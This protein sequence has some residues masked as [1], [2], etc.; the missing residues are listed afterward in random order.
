MLLFLSASCFLFYKPR[1]LVRSGSLE[2]AWDSDMDA[3]DLSKECFKK[4]T[5]EAE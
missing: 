5:K 4:K 2:T 1:G 3:H